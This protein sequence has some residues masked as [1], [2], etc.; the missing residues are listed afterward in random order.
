MHIIVIDDEKI[1]SAGIEKKLLQAEYEVSVLNSYTEYLQSTIQNPDLYLVDVSL[2]DG[3]GF[4]IVASLRGNLKTKDIPILLMSWHDD[5]GTKV[6]WLDIWADDYI[7][8]PFN[9]KELLARVRSHLRRKDIPV[10][11]NVLKYW[12]YRYD[13]NKKE[14]SYKETIIPLTKKERQ[15]LEIFISQKNIFITK[16]SIVEKLWEK[17]DDGTAYN[18]V[19]VTLCNLRKKLWNDFKLETRV[20]EWYILQ[21]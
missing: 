11:K 2:G 9:P 14:I 15:I 16:D 5:I 17:D 13:L 1:L 8:K 6:E 18:T 3:S 20:W 7:V 19:N 4:D 12:D 21:E 10:N